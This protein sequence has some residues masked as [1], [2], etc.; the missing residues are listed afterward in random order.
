[1]I[2]ESLRFVAIAFDMLINDYESTKQKRFGR[3]PF[4]FGGLRRL[5]KGTE[6]SNRHSGIPINTS[7]NIKALEDFVDEV[8]ESLKPMQNAFKLISLGIDYRKYVKFSLYIPL[9]YT[10]ADGSYTTAQ[11]DWGSRGLP[12]IEDVSFCVNFVIES[13]IALQEFDFAIEHD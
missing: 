11:R 4:F 7:L 3:S 6:I 13:A 9:I 1:M 12:K 10:M 8:S 5:P 2:E